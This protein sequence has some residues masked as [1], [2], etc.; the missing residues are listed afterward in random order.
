MVALTLAVILPI[1]VLQ[2]Y[3]I[4]VGRISFEVQLGVAMV[5]SVFAG[6]ALYLAYRSSARNQS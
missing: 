6:L 1:I 3:K 5:L 4:F 2:L